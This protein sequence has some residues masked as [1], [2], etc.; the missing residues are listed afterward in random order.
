[1]VARKQPDEDDDENS[2]LAS[3]LQDISLVFANQDCL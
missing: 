2:I 1:M 3:L